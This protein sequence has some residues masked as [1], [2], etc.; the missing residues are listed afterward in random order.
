AAF[1]AGV[2][3][4]SLSWQTILAAV[5]ATLHARLSTRLERVASA[6]GGVIVVALAARIAADALGVAY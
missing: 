1:V 4:S 5:G 6:L 3:L 2:A